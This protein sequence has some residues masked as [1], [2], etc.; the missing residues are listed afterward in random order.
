MVTVLISC[1]SEKRQITKTARGY[2]EAT[3]A[4]NIDEAMPYACTETR[5]TTLTFLR[6]K[7]L[8]ITDTSYIKSNTPAT[9]KIDSVGINGDTAWVAFTKDTPIQTVQNI[10]KLIKEDN[11]WLV[12]V[13]LQIPNNLLSTGENVSITTHNEK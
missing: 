11:Q 13:P 9:I 8:P 3:A 12:Y 7:I 10:L 4:Y 6:D 1:N 2:L 5:E